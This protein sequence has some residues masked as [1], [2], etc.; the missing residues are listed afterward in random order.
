MKVQKFN[1][2]FKKA[3]QFQL[4]HR[5]QFLIGIALFTIVACSALPRLKLSGNEEEWFD[6]WDTIKISQDRFEEK[7]GA[8][9]SVMAL[10]EAEDV[11]DPEVLTAIDKIGKRLEAEVPYANRVTSLTALSLPVGT[12]EGFEIQNPLEDFSIMDYSQEELREKK[13]FIM[14]RDSLLNVLVSDDCK[15]TWIVLS[16]E[17]YEEP[18]TDAMK[19]IQP[20][21]EKIFNDPEFKSEKF[22]IKPTGMSYTEYEE[23]MVT[24]EQIKTRIFAGFIVMLLCLIFFVRSLRGVIVPVIATVGA[25]GSVLGINSWIGIVGNDQMLM[26]PVLLA[27]ALSVGYSI[28]YINAFRL[29]FR[30]TGK[31]KESVLLAVEESGWPI[32]FTVVTTV[33]GMISFLFADIRPLRWVGGISAAAVF[34]VYVYVII[35]IP[36]FMSFGKDSLPAKNFQAQ[37]GATR[38]D[39]QMEKYGNS[40]IKTRF[41]VIVASV[42]ILVGMIP[43]IFRTKVNMDYTEM[44]GERTPFVAR[45][46]SIL[47][48]KLGSQYSYNVMIEYDEA[49][50]LKSYDVMRRIDGLSEKLG[51]LDSTKVSGGKPRV[52]SVTK[53]IKEMNRTLNSDEPSFYA[54]PE[55]DDLLTQELFL[56]EISGGDDL[57]DWVSQDYSSTYIHIEMSGYDATTIVSDLEKVKAWSAEAFPDARVNVVGEVVNYAIMNGKLV[58]GELKSF[59]GSFVIILLLMAIA[60]SSLHVSLIAMI[61]NVAP[62]IMIGGVMGYFGISLDMITMTV[63]PMILGIAV[64]DTIHFTNHIKYYFEKGCSY[65]DAVL[66]SYREIGKTMGMT[67]VI[68][69]SMFLVI[70][71]STMNCLCRLG[72][73][74]VIGLASALIADYT[75]TPVLVL[76]TK[77]F[78]KEKEAK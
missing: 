3:G 21:A 30:R 68:L 35:L 40:V 25:I 17:D 60:F 45:L 12:E 4:A 42:I 53:I 74:S 28:H 22:T 57:F 16:L 62:V 9:D 58:W 76:L 41:F 72:Y 50:A 7:F 51:S 20:P 13:E 11:F 47:K 39:L 75:L 46:L 1:E 48:G 37:E 44:M 24:E 71:S 66:T 36:I 77:P 14:S 49:D 32:F 29:H 67:T 5:I 73:L 61:P 56:Y 52:T 34:A 18:M 31:R 69:C 54:L 64:D 8:D 38:A 6:D 15:E 26:L 19:K 65:K 78:G 27:M 23:T 63:M 59:V 2:F 33:A 55:D 70:T 10:I 43:G